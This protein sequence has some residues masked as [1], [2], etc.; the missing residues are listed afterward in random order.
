MNEPG[1]AMENFMSSI[2]RSTLT[3]RMATSSGKGDA[4][5][6]ELERMDIA[7]FSLCRCM[8]ISEEKESGGISSSTLINRP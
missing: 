6:D 2:H 7:R 3:P 8:I 5:V 4:N 1:D